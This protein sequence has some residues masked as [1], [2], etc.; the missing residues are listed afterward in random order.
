MLMFWSHPVRAW[1]S[2]KNVHWS[3]VR[4]LHISWMGLY[5]DSFPTPNKIQISSILMFCIACISRT[6]ISVSTVRIM[7]LLQPLTA[8]SLTWANVLLS[9]FLW[10]QSERK[11]L[12][13]DSNLYLDSTPS[14]EVI[15]LSLITD[16]IFRAKYWKSFFRS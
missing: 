11:I 8:T 9:P 14:V 12:L 7:T 1:E 16:V 15:N 5:L 4:I 3:V 2:D 13:F 6:T 10:L